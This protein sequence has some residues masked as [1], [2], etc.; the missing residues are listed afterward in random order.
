V[1]TKEQR[2]HI[3]NAGQQIDSAVL[4][5]VGRHCVVR[6]LDLPGWAVEREGKAFY[7]KDQRSVWHHR[8]Q[9]CAWLLR[10]YLLEE[11]S[12]PQTPHAVAVGD[13]SLRRPNFIFFHQSSAAVRGGS[14]SALGCSL[15]FHA[16]RPILTCR[17]RPRCCVYHSTKACGPKWRRQAFP[18]RVLPARRNA[19]CCTAGAR[20]QSSAW[21]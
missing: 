9:P 15:P 3:G 7:S 21:C 6:C 14:R 16:K 5:E 8:Q 13:G 17:N 4:E 10:R 1:Y 18:S 19:W 20:A 2:A 12:R 11:S